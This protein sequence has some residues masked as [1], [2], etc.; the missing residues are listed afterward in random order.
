MKYK[1]N[2]GGNSSS[3]KNLAYNRRMLELW[4]VQNLE[5]C[6]EAS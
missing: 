1:I 6:V 5:T 4:E 3:S 2:S